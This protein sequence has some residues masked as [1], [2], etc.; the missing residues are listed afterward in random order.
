[1]QAR[2]A[3][4]NIFLEC[5]IFDPRGHK[6]REA[7]D[8][9]TP[10]CKTFADTLCF[11]SHNGLSKFTLKPFKADKRE[12]SKRKTAMRQQNVLIMPRKWTLRIHER[13]KMHT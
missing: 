8:I 6:L 13:N 11:C 4:G 9:V 3:S 12:L 5:F 2:V 7:H 10:F 1:M